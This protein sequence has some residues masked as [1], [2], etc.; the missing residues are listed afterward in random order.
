MARKRRTQIEMETARME[1]AVK[2]LQEVVWDIRKHH[3]ATPEGVAMVSSALM[4][5]A[6]LEHEIGRRLTDS[7]SPLEARLRLEADN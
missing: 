1:R 6:M 7:L 2:L 5:V 3:V 4:T